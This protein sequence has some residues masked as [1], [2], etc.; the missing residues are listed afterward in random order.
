MTKDYEFSQFDVTK[1]NFHFS[2]LTDEEVAQ[3]QKDYETYLTNKAA[4]K[5]IAEKELPTTEVQT[6]EKEEAKSN[7]PK[8]SF[9]P[10]FTPKPSN[11]EGT[12]EKTETTPISIKTEN[13]PKVETKEEDNKTSTT[14]PV[15]KPKIPVKKT[16]NTEQQLITEN[17]NLEDKKEETSK[18]TTTKPVFKPKIPPI[19]K[20][21][22]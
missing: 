6:P 19:K 3:K 17:P 1:M 16:E 5:A 8:P 10:K 4:Q 20:Q 13:Q 11:T 22:E 2:N 12:T 18:I 7:L 21:E 15:F 9:K 14:K